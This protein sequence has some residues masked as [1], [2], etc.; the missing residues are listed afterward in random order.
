[1]KRFVYLH[2]FASSPQS[3]KAQFFHRRFAERGLTL[4]I[5]ELDRNNFKGLTISGQLEVIEAEVQGDPAILIGSSLG[6]YLAAL[7]AAR[8]AN[9]ERLI[10]MA[11]AFQFP[12]RMRERFSE[13]ELEQWRQEGTRLFFHYA[14]QDHRPLGYSF[15]EDSAK[16]EAEPDFRQPALIFH[17]TRDDVVPAEYSVQFAEGHPNV[18]LCLLNSGHELTDVLEPMWAET[19]KFLGF[20]NT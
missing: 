13:A 19:A 3:G 14:F 16:Y 9:I 15:V 2:G 5:A 17:G 10:L 1:M 7:Y 4:Q 8:H 20:Q 12:Q 18:R 11:P 6:G